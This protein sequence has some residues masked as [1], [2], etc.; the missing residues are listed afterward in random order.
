VGEALWLSLATLWTRGGKVGGAGEVRP[1]A[2]RD[3][4]ESNRNEKVLT[5]E[6]KA[7]MALKE[8]CRAGVNA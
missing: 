5:R 3:A 1:K 7:T 8:S 4:E 2:R 6:P